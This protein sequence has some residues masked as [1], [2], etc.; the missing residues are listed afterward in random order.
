MH[1]GRD[2]QA[3]QTGHIP[4]VLYCA[5]V[6][7]DARFIKLSHAFTAFCRRSHSA[8][9]PLQLIPCGLVVRSPSI[10]S[11]PQSICA[12]LGFIAKVLDRILT[13]DHGVDSLEAEA[14]VFHKGG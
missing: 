8:L 11:M 9:Q 1:I 10:A 2:L 4:E 12:G 14:A 7:A 13:F 5:A 3:E 6:A